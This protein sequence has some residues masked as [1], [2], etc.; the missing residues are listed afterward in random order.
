VLG[1]HFFVCRHY[2]LPIF[3]CSFYNFIRGVGV[4]DQ[5]NNHIDFRIIQDV[6]FAECKKRFRERTF[7]ILVFDTDPFDVCLDTRSFF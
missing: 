4:I 7:F 6:I 5:F 1:K 3:Q 2:G